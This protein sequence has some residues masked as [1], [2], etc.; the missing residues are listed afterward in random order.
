LFRMNLVQLLA[1]AL[2][3]VP[4]YGLFENPHEPNAAAE[5]FTAS[6][7]MRTV[8][9][10]LGGELTPDNIKDA[11]KKTLEALNVTGLAYAVVGPKGE[12]IACDGVGVSDEK[13]T[14]VTCDDTLFQIASDTK[15]F[16]ALMALKAQDDGLLD[17]DEDIRNFWP[18]FSPP[19]NLLAGERLSL[20]DAMSHRTGLPRHDNLWEQFS[21]TG[22]T[23]ASDYLR[24]LPFVNPDKRIRY[25]AEYTNAMFLVA[26]EATAH[27]RNTTWEKLLQDSILTPLE[28][29]ATYPTLAS[30]PSEMKDKFATPY[31]NRYPFSSYFSLDTC[32]P[33]GSIVSTA[34]DLAKW[35]KAVLQ[36]CQN[37]PA[38]PLLSCT[39]AKELGKANIP[40]PSYS[41]SYGQY[42]LGMW[43][44]PYKLSSGGSVKLLHHGGNS[45]G[46]TSSVSL[47]PDQ[48][49][50][51][52]ILT[53][54]QASNAGDALALKLIDMVLDQ[55]LADWDAVFGQ[56]QAARR[57]GLPERQAA[58]Y[59]SLLSQGLPPTFA[60]MSNYVGEYWHPSYGKMSVSVDEEAKRLVYKG[61]DGN[62]RAVKHASRDTFLFGDVPDFT[63]DPTK[64]FSVNTLP[65][66]VSFDVVL[67][68]SGQS[69][70]A[71][72]K[73]TFDPKVAP[74]RFFRT[75]FGKRPQYWINTEILPFPT[76]RIG[77]L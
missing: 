55:S 21:V 62:D 48:G 59:K 25:K 27:V 51:I 61:P 50:G 69:A 29:E 26:G 73:T 41:P 72:L 75:E 58:A 7:G 4:T 28:M 10:K 53:N 15:Q 22:A 63:K 36:L 47:L 46:F 1:G 33:A 40:F 38:A 11:A 13:K 43:T 39:L 16:T 19:K 71:S 37:S 34:G 54:E 23:S 20:R 17:I 8:S 35:L 12:L 57:D 30:V 65:L 76:E 52:V 68:A 14:P 67:T 49:Y 2:L 74:V 42:G 6:A 64:I 66:I 3:L 9:A 44:E 77:E 45:I 5:F 60:N 24:R 32:A 56:Q 70:V 31:F 18:A